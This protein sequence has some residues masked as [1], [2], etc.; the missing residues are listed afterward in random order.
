MES[1]TASMEIGTDEVADKSTSPPSFQA[2]V[3]VPSSSPPS[4]DALDQEEQEGGTMRKNEE[5]AKTSISTAIS[6]KPR[7]DDDDGNLPEK[8][9]TDVRSTNLEDD[10]HWCERP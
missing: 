2:T 7:V 10:G 6:D 8:N 4:H 1:H 9:S 5:E 3:S